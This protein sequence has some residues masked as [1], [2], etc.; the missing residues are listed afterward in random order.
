MNIIRYIVLWMIGLCLCPVAWADGSLY[1]SRSV[2]SEGRWVKLRI[3]ETGIYRLSYDDLRSMGFSDPA[4]VSVHGYGGWPLDEDFSQPYIDDLPATPVWRGDDY[5][6]FYGRGPIRWDYNVSTGAFEHTN[7]PYSLYGYYFV[8]DATD[9]SDMPLEASVDGAT[10]RVTA[11]DDYLLHEQ[12][13]V[14]V[15]Q[16]GEIST[17]ASR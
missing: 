10:V 16:S 15:N 11:F 8:T 12:D 3:D 5:I 1:A 9:T 2:L 4:R 14:S 17:V 13:L 7:N 6:L